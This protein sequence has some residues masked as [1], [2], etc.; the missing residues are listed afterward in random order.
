M[1]VVREKDTDC[2]FIYLRMFWVS[3]PALVYCEHVCTFAQLC[4]TVCDPV[5]YSPPGSS[6]SGIFQARIL[7]WVIISFSWEGRPSL[8]AQLVK[9]PLAMWDTWVRS[10]GWGDPLEKGNA[11]HS[12]IL[13]W[14]MPWRG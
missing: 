5:D 6:V 4:P 1:V 2:C 10:L 14:R 8:I 3:S 12:S 13:A 7:E 11:T 9:N